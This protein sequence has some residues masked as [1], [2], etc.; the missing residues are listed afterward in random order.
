M[1]TSPG[2]EAPNL[3]TPSTAPSGPTYLCQPCDAPASTASRAGTSGREHGELILRRLLLEE[4]P[5]RHGDH[6]GLD[7]RF[8]KPLVRGKYRL[9]S[10]PEAIRTRSGAEPGDSVST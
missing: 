1:T 7:A 3:S 10:L 9:T 2:A 6:P 4:L 8:L 5:T